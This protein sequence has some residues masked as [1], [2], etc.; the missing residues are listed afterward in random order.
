MGIDWEPPGALPRDW[1]REVEK[2][3]LVLNCL[4]CGVLG[5]REWFRL[6][7]TRVG[8]GVGHC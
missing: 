7:R 3:A 4:T 8:R 1:T 6:S 2:N 5:I